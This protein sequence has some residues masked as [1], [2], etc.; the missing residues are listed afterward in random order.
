MI[1][2]DEELIKLMDQL[3]TTVALLIAVRIIQIIDSGGQPQVHE[4][5]PIF[6]RHL[7]YY[8]FVFR[9]CDNLDSRPVVEFYVDGNPIGTPY[10][11]AHTIEQLLQHCIRAMHSHMSSLGSAGECPQIIVV[12]THADRENES[13][14]SREAKNEKIHKL[15]SRN[16]ENQIVYYDLAENKVIFPLNALQPGKAE[17]VVVSKIREEFLGN[18]SIQPDD[19]PLGWFALEILL[20]QISATRG[21]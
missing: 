8:L 7:S 14:E 2:T 3:S 10:E 9:L 17:E 1:S 20:E 15:L 18:T 4:I 13:K 6:L 16:L 11:S 5:L 21:S 12:G 19:I